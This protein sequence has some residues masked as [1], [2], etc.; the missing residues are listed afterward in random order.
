M[1]ELFLNQGVNRPLRQ[2]TGAAK[3]I[4][5]IR[6]DKSYPRALI[7]ESLLD[8]HSQYGVMEFSGFSPNPK[9]EE[10]QKGLEAL[11][12]FQPDLVVGCGGGSILD[13][14][15]MLRYFAAT[16][17]TDEEIAN[18]LKGGPVTE[19]A[20]YTPSLVL[21][22]TT[23]GSGAESTEFSVIYFGSAK[24]SFLRKELKPDFVIADPAL[25]RHAPGSVLASSAMD[26]ISQSIESIWARGATSESRQDAREALLLM[27]GS[28]ADAILT[29][30]E[31]SLKNIIKGSNLAGQAIN[32]S[33]TT[34]NHALSYRI[35]SNYGVPHGHCVGM[36]LPEFFKLH[37]KL[38]HQEPQ[39][40][41]S[42]IAAQSEIYSALGFGSSA[43]LVAGFVR[44]IEELGLES[45][46][47]LNSR[48]SFEAAPIVDSVN[49]ERLG[50][51][52]I[53]LTRDD[54]LSLFD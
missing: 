15:K 25:I 47:T 44:F 7:N 37:E 54:L 13:M 12:D 17:G 53:E 34:G 35:T 11:R 27:W 36:L 40:A 5:V 18:A 23:A 21:M 22:P 42:A 48:Y 49:V 6:G 8:V 28:A 38:W 32:V 9:Y 4:A 43:E 3:R 31:D 2:I 41:Q 26:A 10:F 51:H 24:Y 33:K 52:P 1:T 16:S 20:A 45:F 46:A 39:R 29:R 19:S 14:A 50:N 30:S